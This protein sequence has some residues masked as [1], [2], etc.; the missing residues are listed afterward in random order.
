MTFKWASDHLWTKIRDLLPCGAT[1]RMSE[2][3][4]LCRLGK[5]ERIENR[6]RREGG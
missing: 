3:M 1:K 6:E 2:L 4:E 5:R